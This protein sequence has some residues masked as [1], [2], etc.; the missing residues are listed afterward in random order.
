[1]EYITAT[2]DM[3][4]AIRDVLHTTIKT[5]YPKFYPKEETELFCRHSLWEYGRAG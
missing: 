5:V 2:L 4:D 1:M 3:A